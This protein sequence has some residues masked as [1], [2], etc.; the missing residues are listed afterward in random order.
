MGVSEETATAGI[1][2]SA[3]AY[4]S[5]VRVPNLFTAPPDVLLGAALAVAVG[6]SVSP[7]A[8][9]GVAGASVALY[10]AGTTLNDYF[11]APEDA[12]ERPERPIPAGQISRSRALAL[13]TT[14][15]GV[16]IVI[17]GLA[18]G[19]GGTVT[20]A[21]V[22]LTVILYDGALKGSTGGFLVMGAARGLNVTLGMTATGEL[23]TVLPSHA[24]AVPVVVS[25]YIAS[26]TYMAARERSGGNRGAVVVAATGAT[27]AALAAIIAGS[28]YRPTTMTFGATV[29]FTFAFVGWVGH[30]LWRAYLNPVPETVGPAV[31]RCVLGLIVLDAAFAVVAGVGWGLLTLSFLVPAMGL[32]R[33]FD[34]T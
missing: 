18:A 24:L 15:L 26:V 10:A 34:V 8:V 30:A 1:R 31:G 23:P 19:V 32:A 29:L 5:L 25:I 11:D 21:I 22:A 16:G 33:V 6:R 14:L 3:A 20:A 12:V 9:A 17:A 4:L 2:R 27:V 7:I 28:L 13:G